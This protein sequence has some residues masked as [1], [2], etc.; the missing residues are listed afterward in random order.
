MKPNRDSLTDG[1]AV[2]PTN[3]TADCGPGCDC[4]STSGSGRA[5]LVISLVVL[6]AVTVIVAYKMLN[7]NQ[8][9]ASN[10]VAG[11]KEAEVFTISTAARNEPIEREPSAQVRSGPDNTGLSAKGSTRIG[12]YLESIGELNKV[13]LNQDVVFIYIPAKNDKAASETT[14]TAVLSAQKTLNTKSIKVGLYTLKTTS[15]DFPLMS[16]RVQV[17]AILVVCKGRGMGTVSGEVTET[18][19]LQ[20]FMVSS[21][22]GGCCPSGTDSSTCK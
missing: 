14:R 15:P 9:D 10:T 5:K 11:R 7:D 18:K 17:P 13:A 1:L 2:K 6:L 4:G 12:K 3:E 21:R 20:A 16:S 8:Q 19:L 22:A